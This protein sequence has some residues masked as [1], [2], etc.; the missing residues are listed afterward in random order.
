[1]K[2]V[3]VSIPASEV[4][5]RQWRVEDTLAA[6]VATWQEEDRCEEEEQQL[7]ER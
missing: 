3:R 7:R 1:M 6:M 5:K 4:D 2:Y